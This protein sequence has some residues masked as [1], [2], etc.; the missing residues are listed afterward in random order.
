MRKL[1]HTL[2]M[3]LVS[4]HAAEIFALVERER[5]YAERAYRR[6]AGLRRAARIAAAQAAVAAAQA[7]Q[8]AK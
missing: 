8:P 3:K 2:F 6:E 7:A 5:R 4:A 1:T